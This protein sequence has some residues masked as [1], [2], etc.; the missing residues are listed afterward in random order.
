LFGQRPAPLGPDEDMLGVFGDVAKDQYMTDTSA[1]PKDS[2]LSAITNEL[3]NR[4]SQSNVGEAAATGTPPYDQRVAQEIISEKRG[5]I[6]D[7][8]PPLLSW[9]NQTAPPQDALTIHRQQQQQR[10]REEK[11][12][13]QELNDI[14][15]L[16]NVL[17]NLAS[18]RDQKVPKPEAADH[19]SQCHLE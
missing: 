15:I 2:S 9:L 12:T 8:V 3:S 1:F 10:D 5:S 17:I 18:Q 13:A 19:E 4:R 7:Q 16:R 6:L 11:A 14:E